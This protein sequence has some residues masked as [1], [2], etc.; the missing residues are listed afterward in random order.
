MAAAP[1]LPSYEHSFFYAMG[2]RNRSMRSTRRLASSPV[3]FPQGGPEVPHF[4][5]SRAPELTRDRP[6]DA[7]VGRLREGT[8]NIKIIPSSAWAGRNIV[9][10]E[11]DAARR[12]REMANASRQLRE[13]EMVPDFGWLGALA[14]PLI[15]RPMDGSI[16]LDRFNLRRRSIRSVLPSSQSADGM[17]NRRPRHRRSRNHKTWPMHGRNQVRPQ[18]AR[19]GSM[20]GPNSNPR[21]V[22]MVTCAYATLRFN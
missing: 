10:D 18:S 19:S 5:G 12:R 9:P 7:A 14:G 1:V 4:Q 15:R 13:V 20:P 8:S 3:P 22:A 6:V 17:Y 21:C 2:R 16:R 11:S